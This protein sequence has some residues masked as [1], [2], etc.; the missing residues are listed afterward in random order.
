M[1]GDPHRVLE[2]MIIG[3]YAI[4]AKEGYIYVR[5]EYPLAIRR[6]ET[7]I[8]QAK[9]AGLIGENILGTKFSFDLHIN[10]GAGA[11]VCEVLSLAGPELLPVA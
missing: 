11:F 7:A 3:A 6:L 5:A 2:G 8:K 1:E 9:K 4:G 10:K